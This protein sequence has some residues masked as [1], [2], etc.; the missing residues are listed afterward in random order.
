MQ[1]TW[2][3]SELG[4]GTYKEM[5]FWGLHHQLPQKFNLIF[6]SSNGC[7]KAADISEKSIIIVFLLL[8]Y[9][10]DTKSVISAAAIWIGQEVEEDKKN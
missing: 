7:K 9:R 1:K 4:S 8:I 6:S 10:F 2:L 5:K 3:S